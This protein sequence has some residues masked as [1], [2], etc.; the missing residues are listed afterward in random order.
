MA[1]VRE[2]FVSL[3][4]A[5]LSL[6]CLAIT[7]GELFTWAAS[8]YPQF[9]PGKPVVGRHL[10]YD[11]RY[12][13]S[14]NY[15][16]VDDADDVYMLGPDSGNSIMFVG[17][18]T[19]FTPAVLAWQATQP[20]SAY[21]SQVL[22]SAWHQDGSVATIWD[23]G[24]MTNYKINRFAIYSNFGLFPMGRPPATQQIGSNTYLR[25]IDGADTIVMD[26]PKNQPFYFTA[27]WK[28][29]TI[30]TVYMRADGRGS[31]LLIDDDQPH[32]LELPYDFAVSE[33]QVAQNLAA[34]KTLSAQAQS[35]MT[36][37][38]ASMNAATGAA[39]PPARAMAAYTAL[40][41]IMPLKERLVLDASNQAIASQR[42]DF[43]LNYEGFESWTDTQHVPGYTVARDAGFKSVY[44]NVD[45]NRISPS[46]GVF[47]FSS[48]DYSI[49][50]A[51]A[52][53]FRVDL[54]IINKPSQPRWAQNYSFDALKTLY[55]DLAY[56]LVARYGGQVARY[57]T[58]GEMEL[59]TGGLTLPQAAELARQSLNGAREASPGTPFGYYVSASA[60][61][62]YQMNPGPQ[63]DYF[64]GLDLI[65]Y[66]ARH[67][68][69]HDFIGLQMQYGTTFA[70]ID[71]QRFQEIVQTVHEIA[72]VPIYMG[73]TGSSSMTQDYGIPAQF[74]WHDGLTQQSQHDW[75]DGTLRILYA[76][77]YVKGYYWVHLDPD[78]HDYGSDYLSGL[79]GTGL[80]RADGTV[81]KVRDAFKGFTTQVKQ[82]PLQ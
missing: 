46:P 15:L 39:S 7:N 59:Q 54:N 79:I 51:R 69:L 3:C 72:R 75:A 12:Y 82:L 16:A 29:P 31:G 77:P 63:A 33:F 64:S 45:W 23:F 27:L 81:K 19:D 52:L 42:S 57:Y 49:E 53:G 20:A 67:S 70:P 32:K 35:L 13:P 48:L 37:A 61:V 2:L 58:A 21:K 50:R 80:V 76:M 74:Y 24:D 60:Y 47:D 25:H 5:V 38:I 17:K 44:T 28:A 10:Q 71:L 26:V 56:L 8:A 1:A 18:L 43:D 9:F 73:E 41:S 65:A 62:G 34:G 11:F 30:G 36:Q 4:L 78:N 68:I 6:Q 22:V 14:G 66:M 40:S 55:R